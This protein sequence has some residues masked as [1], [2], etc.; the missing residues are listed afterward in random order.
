MIGAV[1]NRWG[2]AMMALAVG[3]GLVGGIRAADEPVAGLKKAIAAIEAKRYPAA[4]A[5]LKDVRVPKLADYTAWYLAS[6]QFESKNY[7][8]AVAALE[9]VF[10]NEPVSPLLGGAVLLAADAYLKNGQPAEVVRFVREHYATLTPPQGEMALADAYL[11]LGDKG[12]AAVY[13]QRVYYGYPQSPAAPRAGIEAGKLEAELGDGYPVVMAHSLL[14]RATKLLE[15]GQTASARK[16]FLAIIPRLAGEEQDIARVRMGTA[17]YLANQN[18]AAFAYLNELKVASPEAEA[19][20]LNYLSQSARRLNRLGDMDTFARQAA[21]KYPSSPWT[22][23]ALFAAGNKYLVENQ[24]AQYEPLYRACYQGLPGDSRTDLCHWK[25]TWAHYMRRDSDA[26]EMLLEHLRL[27]PGSGQSSAALYFLGRLAEQENDDAR[28]GGFYQE[29]AA[30]FPNQFYTRLSGDRLEQ[31]KGVQAAAAAAGVLKDVAF[32]QRASAREFTATS[33]TIQRMERADLLM[34]GGLDELAERELR[35]GADR[36]EQSHVLA[37]E[38]AKLT[39][40]D[41]P[42]QALRYI[43]RYVSG[44]MAMPLDT[45]PREFW[46]MAFPLPYRDTLERYSRE[47]ELDPF[48]LAGLIRQESEF[49]AKVVSRAGAR[50]L[51]QIMPST[52]RDIG[53][54]LKVAFTPAKLFQPE[55][56]LQFGAYYF[57]LMTTRLDGNEVA[58]LAAYNAGLTRARAWLKWGDFREPAEFIET[59]PLSETRNYVQAVLRNAATYREV[60]GMDLRAWGRPSACAGP[61]GPAC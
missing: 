20:R 11:A 22:I 40:K 38:L 50:G 57:K 39:G 27:Y 46:Q 52:G 18:A 25:V 19:E 55:Y 51:T 26:H 15:A 59:I 36:G 9:P 47:R 29:A 45:A 41:D 43:K 17:Q 31:L 44:Y 1:H 8:A 32:P 54:T 16:E 48:L 33:A 61:I 13:Y 10:Q 28:A 4:I 6:A 14:G 35:F 7:A 58:A 37:V 2:A 30:H 24:V 53:K 3:A 60:Y 34:R 21:E 42:A 5:E 12:S 49:D 56:N 23:D